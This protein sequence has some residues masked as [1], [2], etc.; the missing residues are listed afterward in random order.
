MRRNKEQRVSKAIHFGFGT[1][2]G[3][4][5]GALAEYRPQ[6]TKGRGTLFGAGLNVLTHETL[7]P[8]LGLADWPLQQTP[9][10]QSSEAATHLLYGLVTESTRS[11][12]RSR[13]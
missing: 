6:V 5:Y 1:I 12:V 10:E 13:I 11:F 8:I 9:R 3:A 7:L 4:A 2:A